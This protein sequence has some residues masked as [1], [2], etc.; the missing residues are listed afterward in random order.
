[1]GYE[2]ISLPNGGEGPPTRGNN[3]CIVGILCDF[4]VFCAPDPLCGFD[5]YCNSNPGCDDCMCDFDI[6]CDPF[7]PESVG[8][9]IRPR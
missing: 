7:G 8:R 9:G 1:M 4:N 3:G 2:I 5:P 6:G